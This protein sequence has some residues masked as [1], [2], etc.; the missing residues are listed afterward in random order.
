MAAPLIATLELDEA[1]FQFFEGRRQRHFP[2]RLNIVPAHLTLFHHLPGKEIEAVR[3]DLEQECRWVAPFALTVSG[4]KFMGRGV[5]YT[6]VSAELASLRARLANG[7][8]DWLTG[9]DRQRHQPHVTVQNKVEPA[10]ARLLQAEL[11]RDFRP[12]QVEARGVSLWHYMGGPWEPAGKFAF[13]APAAPHDHGPA[14][15]PQLS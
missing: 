14:E 15:P 12:F 13:T 4:L 5:A 11:T 10:Q 9:Q 3:L 2:P 8:A 7:W 6:L 1:S